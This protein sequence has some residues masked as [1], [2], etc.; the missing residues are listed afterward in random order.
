LDVHFPA[1]VSDV[2]KDLVSDLKQIAADS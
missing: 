2:D 1:G